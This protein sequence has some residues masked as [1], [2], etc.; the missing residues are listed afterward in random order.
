[1]DFENMV[2]AVRTGTIVARSQKAARS[3]D[4]RTGQHNR[5]AVGKTLD[6]QIQA[7]A[8]SAGRATYSGSKMSGNRIRTE[9]AN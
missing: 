4:S 8:M 5:G 2:E 9:R 7:A 1:V 3:W 6:Q